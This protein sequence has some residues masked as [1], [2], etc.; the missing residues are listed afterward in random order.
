MYHWKDWYWS[1]SSNTLATWCEEPTHWKRTGCWERMKTRGDGDN[2]GWD[3]WMASLIQWT[4]VWA[5]SRSWWRTGNPGVLQ[6]V[7]HRVRYDWAAE[8]QQLSVCRVS[9][10]LRRIFYCFSIFSDVIRKQRYITPECFLFSRRLQFGTE[11]EC[12]FFS[13]T[14]SNLGASA[15]CPTI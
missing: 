14:P 4:W 6:S 11:T 10:I 15:V 13:P 12:E 8:Q 7:G 5:S 3:G 9:T 2:R 1:W